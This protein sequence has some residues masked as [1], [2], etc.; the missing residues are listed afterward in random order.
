M[1]QSTAE[2]LGGYIR[3]I[4]DTVSQRFVNRSPP[5]GHALF[6]SSSGYLR[7][8]VALVT[9]ANTGIG[10]ETSRSLAAAGATVV[11][12]C[13]NRGKAEAAAQAIRLAVPDA[14]IQIENLDLS[15]LSSVRDCVHTF[16]SRTASAAA[17]RPLHILV[18]NGGVMGAP[19][20]SPETHF[21]VNHVGHAL[22]TLLLLP[23]LLAAQNETTR[24]VL[25]SSLTSVISD[26]R[27]NDLDFKARKYNWMTAY[28]NSKLAM[29]LFMKALVRR[30]GS[31]PITVNAV[32]PGEAT[33]DVARYLGRVW[34]WLH[35]NVGK[36][37]LL[38]TAE[39]AR[40]SV[41]VAGAKEIGKDTGHMFHRVWHKMEIPERLLDEED[42]E[43]LWEVTLAMAE[44]RTEDLDT[45]TR[46]ALAHGVDKTLIR[47]PP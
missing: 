19:Q 24:V 46:I 23:N 32:H 21:F 47:V 44:V 4:G 25:V 13:R 22:L 16:A 27:W 40:T 41:Y 37:F 35:Q 2:Y 33:S 43:R 29:L 5:Q 17:P 34:M 42:V 15:S 1:P 7:G 20:S 6:H 9:G 11:L 39:S 38:S 8:K 3:L 30:L 26:L 18:L 31:A 36:F 10:F 28:A 45:L 12:A 14:N